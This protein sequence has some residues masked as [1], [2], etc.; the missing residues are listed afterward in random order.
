MY[1]YSDIV[2]IRPPIPDLH[3]D[4]DVILDQCLTYIKTRMYLNT[5]VTAIAFCDVVILIAV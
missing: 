2:V 1:S 4:S 5:F 3:Q